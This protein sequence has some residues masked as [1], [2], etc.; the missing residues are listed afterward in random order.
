MSHELRAYARTLARSL[1]EL[2]DMN[3]L[4]REDINCL[5]DKFDS[6]WASQTFR[7]LV[8]RAC[9]SHIEAVVFGLKQISLTAQNLGSGDISGKTRAFL[10]ERQIV[11]NTVGDATIISVRA[12]T[13]KNVKLTLKLAARLFDVSWQPQFSGSE[14]PLFRESV[15]IRH[16]IT[17]PKSLKELEITD[18]EYDSHKTAYLWFTG[19]FTRFLES[20]LSKHGA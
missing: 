13:I 14:W 15:Q 9:W 20:M 16:R 18:D 8:V 10:E 7:R 5:L 17:H 6:D 1:D 4:L 3:T 19:G 12:D 2:L 11:V